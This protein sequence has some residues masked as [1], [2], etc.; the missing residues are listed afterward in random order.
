MSIEA[1]IERIRSA[2]EN[3]EFYG[4]QEAASVDRL[5][6]ILDVKLP[7]SYR[8]FLQQYG[9]GY[10]FIGLYGN[11]PESLELGCLLGDTVRIRQQYQLPRQFIPIRTSALGGIYALDT[12]AVGDSGEY[13]VILITIGPD[14]QLTHQIKASASFGSYLQELLEERL[15]LILEEQESEEG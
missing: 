9:G 6:T 1:L 7:H 2:G 14:G 13:P 15:A 12:S 5:E 3:P 11:Q 10:G 4:P 8:E